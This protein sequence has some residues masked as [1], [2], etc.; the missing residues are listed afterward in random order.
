MDPHEQLVPV[1]TVALDVDK[2]ITP[3]TLSLLICDGSGSMEIHG[4]API[5]CMNR[6]LAT[7]R[8]PPD[9]R[10]Q[11]A[12]IVTFSEGYKVVVPLSAVK[13]IRLLNELNYRQYFSYQ[14]TLLWRTVKRFLAEFNAGYRILPPDKRNLLRVC[15]GVISDGADNRSDTVRYPKR[16]QEESARSLALGFELLAYGLGIDGQQ[17]ARDLGFPEDDAHAMTVEATRAGLDCVTQHFSETTT[18]GGGWSPK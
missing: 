6:H 5:A 17:L 3:T 15:I 10:E 9:G 2:L 7:L 11:V 8:N 12:M 14:G 1:E 4:N 16:V 13:D 18:G